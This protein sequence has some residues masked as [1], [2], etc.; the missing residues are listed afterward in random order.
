MTVTRRV[1]KVSPKLVCPSCAGSMDY[2]R[3][4]KPEKGVR[5]DI[6]LYSCAECG[7]SITSVDHQ[8]IG[9]PTRR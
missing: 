9:R 2:I 8:P 5:R 4:L 7:V 3:G 1:S 6:H